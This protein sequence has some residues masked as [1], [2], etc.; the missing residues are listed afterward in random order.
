MSREQEPDPEYTDEELQQISDD[1]DKEEL[2]E[3]N[4]EKRNQ[5]FED[6]NDGSNQSIPGYVDND[7]GFHLEINNTQASRFEVEDAEGNIKTPYADINRDYSNANLERNEIE[8]IRIFNTLY[9]LCGDIKAKESGGWVLRKIYAMIATSR[10][11]NGFERKMTVSQFTHGS[12]KSEQKNVDEKPSS[13]LMF[14][15]KKKSSGGGGYN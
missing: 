7:L 4:E 13:F 8:Q 9:Q 15:K 2:Q 1:A 11:R 3:L 12:M 10:S 6:A 14:A 5:F